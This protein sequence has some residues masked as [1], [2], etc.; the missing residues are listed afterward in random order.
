MTVTADADG[1]YA[2]P[3]G[4]LRVWT[5]DG[6][7][8]RDGRSVAAEGDYVAPGTYTLE[9]LGVP[10]GGGTATLY[11]EALRPSLAPADRRIEVRVRCGDHGVMD[12][13]VRCSGIEMT[14]VVEDP[15]GGR[16]IETTGSHLSM[17]APVV[18]VT[19]MRLVIAPVQNGSTLDGLLQVRGTVKSRFLDS[20]PGTDG[21]IDAIRVYH[22]E[23]SEPIVVGRVSAQKETSPDPLRPYPYQGRF[24][25]NIQVTGLAPGSNRFRLTAEDK[26][27]R[28]TGS[29]A[30]TIDVTSNQP[31]PRNDDDTTTPP[32]VAVAAAPG[33]TASGAKDAAVAAAPAPPQV[34][35]AA[36]DPLQVVATTEKTRFMSVRLDGA[37]S[38]SVAAK[39]GQRWGD[40]GGSS[41]FT[42]V[43]DGKFYLASRYDAQRPALLLV[44]NG[45][46]DDEPA[47]NRIVNKLKFDAGVVVG[48]FSCGVEMVEGIWHLGVGVVKG[49]GTLYGSTQELVTWSV[50]SL[51]FGSDAGEEF[52]QNDRVHSVK[53]EEALKL[54]AEMAES[55][56]KVLLKLHLDQVNA[57]RH[58]LN[59][60]DEELGK[61]S[62]EYR[63]YLLFGAEIF[64]ELM[65]EIAAKTPYEQGKIVG[66][67]VCEIGS[68]FIGVGEIAALTKIRYL[69]KIEEAG[70]LGKYFKDA[71]R[72]ERLRQMIRAI[73]YAKLCFPAGTLV[74]AAQGL[75]PIEAVRPGMEVWARSD[76][77]EVRLR[78]VQDTVTTRPDSLIRFAFRDRSGRDASIACTAQHP[79][80]V[81]EARAFVDADHLAPGQHLRLRDGESAEIASVV[82][83]PHEGR[84][85]NLVV[86]DDH[87]YFVAVAGVLVHNA[88]GRRLCEEASS[89][90]RNMWST[91]PQG[92]K[93]IDVLADFVRVRKEKLNGELAA[94]MMEEMAEVTSG[95]I[96]EAQDVLVKFDDPHKT[97]WFM[98]R[99]HEVLTK[100]PRDISAEAEIRACV[101]L[102]REGRAV[103]WRNNDARP[104]LPTSD[105]FL[106]AGVASANRYDVYSPPNG[107]NRQSIFD[108]LHE[109]T[110]IRASGENQANK[111]I[112]DLTQQAPGSPHVPDAGYW[113]QILA[114]FNATRAPEAQ[115]LELKVLL[116]DAIA[117]TITP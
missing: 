75:V 26:V 4:A 30:A 91:K 20:I 32:V 112:V 66:T 104:G 47:G 101:A 2:R 106:D 72:L 103:H 11:L 49:V 85:F 99:I 102:R 37:F 16:F 92:S 38:D 78:L 64:S 96:R 60:E 94:G 17:P 40:E 18:E 13:A 114:E 19:S 41:T 113:R 9:Q 27:L 83:E 43:N 53:V 15:A 50:V 21:T 115:V 69:E 68:L 54:T 105:F 90:L 97:D 81:D 61:M 56:A 52:Y 8:S 58:L 23:L 88:N 79:V 5:K 45:N 46:H 93:S 65:K 73:R 7:A 22:N 109:K 100:Q 76:D 59:G 42:R 57:I 107:V 98:K 80:W 29:F 44:L 77:G 10:R 25:L 71:G 1:G 14:T 48:I 70:I 12:D 35:W 116:D 39:F 82:V 110:R 28:R 33:K 62:D 87:T 111:F 51:F 74:H 34:R 24:T 86:A 84:A 36:G 89:L 55:V 117:L 3:A 67:L 95:V 6:G 31:P 63:V 108:K